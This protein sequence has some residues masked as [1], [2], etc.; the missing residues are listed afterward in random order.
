V[1]RKALINGWYIVAAV[2]AVFAIQSWWIESQQFETIPYSQF[3][4]MID[5]G[6][7]KSVRVTDKYITGTLKETPPDG[8]SR[9]V[10]VRVELGLAKQLEEHGITVEGAVEN[11]LIRDILSWILPALL[12]CG[13]WAFF[14]RRFAEK[15]GMGGLMSIGKSKAKVYMEKDVTI[16]FD[17]VAGVEEA[18]DEL[19]EID[20]IS[21]KPQELWTAWSAHSGYCAQHGG[22]LRLARQAGLVTYETPRQTFLGENAFAHFAERGFSEDTAREI[23]CAVRELITGAF[24]KALGILRKYRSQLERGAQLLLEK[25]TLMREELPP[26]QELQPPI[27]AATGVTI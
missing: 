13:K 19:R 11:N 14:I 24:E 10:T 20:D 9:F 7:I 25:E 5:A 2:L 27:A 17:D 15:Q 26:L 1:D 16:R 12:F 6:K 8:R 23:D 22:A 3:E 21:E 18:K 4:Q